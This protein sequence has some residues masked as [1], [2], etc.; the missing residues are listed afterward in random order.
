MQ[1]RDRLAQALELWRGP[2]YADFAGETFARAEAA[3]LEEQRAVAL[4]DRVLA[5]LALGEHAAVIGER[6][7]LVDRQPLREQ[8][9][10][11]LVLAL[12]RA[13]RQGDALAAYRRCRDVGRDATADVWVS[14]DV[15]VSRLHARLECRPEGR[16]ASRARRRPTAPPSRAC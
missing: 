14:W 16:A 3:R 12:C 11:H 4:E 8:L 15:R 5:D 2:A 1:A 9:W 7:H 13:G 10:A 6:Q